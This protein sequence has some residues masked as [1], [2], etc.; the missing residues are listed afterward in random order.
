[1]QISFL[2]FLSNFDSSS[3]N[4][5]IGKQLQNLYQET[6]PFS[7]L[8]AYGHKMKGLNPVTLQ[9]IPQEVSSH[10]ILSIQQN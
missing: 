9:V 8:C 7:F 3:K 1:M 10:R 4:K 5:K 2:L 6:T